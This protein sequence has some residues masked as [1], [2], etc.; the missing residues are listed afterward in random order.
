P[1]KLPQTLLSSAGLPVPSIEI[2]S[3]LTRHSMA[4]SASTTA[5]RCAPRRPPAHCVFKR[6]LG[7][8]ALSALCAYCSTA[9]AQATA[10]LARDA[11]AAAL[12]PAITVTSAPDEGV[13]AT[14]KIPQSIKD[15]PQ[16]ITVIDQ[17]RMQE[18]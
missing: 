17:E 13:A 9:L 16:S 10:P 5:A 7:G 8:A 6:H 1:E 15:T 3:Q 14:T 4:D 12:L 11:A 18:Q 2:N